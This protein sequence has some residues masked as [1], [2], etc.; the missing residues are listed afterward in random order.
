MKKVEKHLIL[1]ALVSEIIYASEETKKINKNHVH[2]LDSGHGKS[3]KDL[4]LKLN[5]QFFENEPKMIETNIK[6][7]NEKMKEL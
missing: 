2:S 4:Y 7:F 3:Y 5:N 6:Y 1:N